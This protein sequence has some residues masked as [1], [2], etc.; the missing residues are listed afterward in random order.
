MRRPADRGPVRGECR[1]RGDHHGLSVLGE[2]HRVRG[3]VRA[4]RHAA[5]RTELPGRRRPRGG[6]RHRGRSGRL[7]H[8]VSRRAVLSLDQH[9]RRHLHG[10]RGGPV[11]R[12]EAGLQRHPLGRRRRRAHLA[13]LARRRPAGE[14]RRL[15]ERRDDLHRVDERDRV[16]GPRR[17]H[18]LR[19]HRSTHVPRSLRRVPVTTRQGTPPRSRPGGLRLGDAL[20]LIVIR[21][22][23]INPATSSYDD[24]TKSVPACCSQRDRP[25]KRVR[26]G[27]RLGDA[28]RL[29]VIRKNSINP[30]AS[31]YDDMTKSVPALENAVLMASAR[32]T[33]SRRG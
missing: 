9:R 4:E 28:D 22:N 19:G 25:S 23:Q 31:S 5:L 18:G 11:A 24:M 3:R 17:V 15:T 8:G 14:R 2:V 12:S 29:I 21:K 16:A 7:R 26:G 30:A 27:L 32:G 6:A 1:S 20:R 33:G 10:R 13:G